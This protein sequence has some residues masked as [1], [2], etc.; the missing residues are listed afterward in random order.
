[1]RKQD[2][3]IQLIKSLDPSE[4]RYFR[5]FSSLQSGEKKYLQL[6]DLLEGVDEYNASELSQKL[7]VTM[8]HLGGIK[9]YLNDTLLGS[10]R[11]ISEQTTEIA[12]LYVA[13]EDARILLSRR[14]FVQAVDLAEKTSARAMQLDQFEVVIELLNIRYIGLLNSQRLEE[15]A[16][17]C[18]EY[19]QIAELEAE[20]MA[21][22]RLKAMATFYEIR[23]NKPDEFKKLCED[24]LIEHG[25]EKLKSIRSKS[26]WY[27]IVYRYYMSSDQVTKVLEISRQEWECYLANPIIKISNGSAYITS[28]TRLQY[29]EHVNGNSA[30][31]LELAEQLKLTLNDGS[32]DLSKARRT[33]FMAYNESFRMYVLLRLER[34]D[35]VLKESPAVIELMKS[36][37]LPEQYANI[38]NYALA[39]VYAGEHSRAIDELNKLL[40]INTE[41]R[42][43]LQQLSRLLLV[44]VQLDCGNYSLIPYHIKAAKSWMKRHNYENKIVEELYKHFLAASKAT[45][46]EKRK[47]Y[48]QMFELM[49]GGKFQPLADVIMLPYWLKTRA[50]SPN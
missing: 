49:E 2:Y 31:A 24:P 20:V 35:K 26:V 48:Q 29:M 16:A 45:N 17:V 40:E 11:N 36:R 5:L 13:K 14:L 15:A 30:R 6:F 22:C 9:H 23:R 50:V 8:N 18:D 37:P 39:L 28:F 47:I 34:F 7:D 38:F 33:T 10:L 19:K 3:I 21:L 43:D 42:V 27:D 25:P 41:L 46:R 1:M 44:M 4:R 12:S 32:V